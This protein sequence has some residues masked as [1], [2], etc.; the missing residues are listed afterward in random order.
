MENDVW[1]SVLDTLT[2][3]QL[4]R[5]EN[6]AFLQCAIRGKLIYSMKRALIFRLSLVPQN[7]NTFFSLFQR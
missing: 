5:L 3:S 1:S 6:E 7:C 2:E 4:S